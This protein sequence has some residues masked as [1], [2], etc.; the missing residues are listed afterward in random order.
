MTLFALAIGIAIS[1]P[2]ALLATRV[3]WLEWPVLA[4]A[5][6]MQTVPALAL[7]ALMV[8]LL[9]RI[10]FAP[11]LA[12][13]VLYSMFPVLRNTVT[14][15][16]GV[17]PAYIEAARAIGMTDAQLLLRVQLPLA[18]PV[19]IAG[20]RISAVWVV[21]VATL[22]T[23]VGF[24]SL[25]NYIFSGLQTQNFVAV[26]VGV[27]P[28]LLWRCCLIFSSGSSRLRSR[29]ETSSSPLAP[30]SGLRSLLCRRCC[31]PSRRPEVGGNPR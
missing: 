31:L 17:D 11:A 21:G 2:V 24:P 14:G 22:S 6:V 12:G 1:I 3:K 26:L 27:R 25:G 30:F 4:F 9:G 29:G 20:I 23:P 10:G 19:I 18:A 28:R 15:V 7:L 16:E 5:G 8:P 13:L